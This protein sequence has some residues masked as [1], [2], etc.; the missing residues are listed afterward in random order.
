MAVE[1][2]LAVDEAERVAKLSNEELEAELRAEGFDLEALPS[3]EVLLARA[4]AKLKKRDAAREAARSAITVRYRSGPASSRRPG[5][6]QKRSW[7]PEWLAAAAVLALV[8]S[9]V[10]FVER[11]SIARW[12]NG[13][14]VI[15][16]DEARVPSPS[17]PSALEAAA[18][19]REEAQDAWDHG[20]WKRCG[21]KLDEAAKLDPAGDKD[22][23]VKDLRDD[24]ARYTAPPGP[25]PDKK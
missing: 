15:T 14:R 16:P 19:L 21:E 5:A 2:M 11:E 9:A 24:V 17:P 6:E 1:D 13:D 22:P 3:A 7:T 20:Q 4:E 12:L 8:A 18:H 23:H 10:G 25:G